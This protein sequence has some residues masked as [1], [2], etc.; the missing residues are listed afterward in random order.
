M[1]LSDLHPEAAVPAPRGFDLARWQAL[2]NAAPAAAPWLSLPQ[3]VRRSSQGRPWPGLA[4][5]HQVGPEGDLYV[6]PMASHTILVRRAVPTHLVQRHGLVTKATPWQP[7]E[8]LVVPAGLPTFWR[9]EQ[10]RDNLHIDLAPAWLQRS[11]QADVALQSCFGRADPVLAGFAQL[12][13]ASLDTD[14]SLNQAFAERIAEAIALHLLEHH[15]RPSRALRGPGGLSHRQ[16]QRVEEAVRADLGARWTIERLAR[17]AELSPFHFARAFKASAGASPH[18]W[19]RLQRMEAAARLVRE[20]ALPLAEIGSLTG[21]R[22]AAHFA[23]A[24]RRH[25]GVSP[26]AYRRAC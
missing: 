12:L 16:L 8:S 4:L 26:S 1:S 11:A 2:E 15:A 21:H 6:P 7:G 20:G 14:T 10:P 25:W 22:S 5:W 23:Q 9:S 19:L 3:S 13:L 18:A 17:L 24:F